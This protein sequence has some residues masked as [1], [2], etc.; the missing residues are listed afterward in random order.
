MP[1]DAEFRARR[2][3]CGATQRDIAKEAGV[4]VQSVKL[5]ERGVHPLASCG[6]DALEEF[7]AE[8]CLWEMQ[9]QHLVET[10]PAELMRG[11]VRIPFFRSQEDLD[12][13]LSTLA[14]A[15]RLERILAGVENLSGETRLLRR[16]ISFTRMNASMLRAAEVIAEN[17]GFSEHY[18]VDQLIEDESLQKM[19]PLI[20]EKQDPLANPEFFDPAAGP[21]V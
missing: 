2:E 3:R 12:F 1:H 9:A 5:W 17:S 21:H 14:P 6:V 16:E 10:A 7:E 4:T 20:T 8:Y 13:Y 15:T 11:C 19:R 18:Y